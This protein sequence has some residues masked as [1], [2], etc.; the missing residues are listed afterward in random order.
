[1]TH[2]PEQLS[3]HGRT[4]EA[5]RAGHG[6]PLIVLE[7]GLGDDWSSWSSVLAPLAQRS[8]LLAYSRPG[9]GTSAAASTPRDIRTEAREL[10]ELLR[11]LG[12]RSP[13]LLVGH[14]LGGLI[15]QA[16]A[17]R[18]PNDVA[19]L[20]LVDAPH[21]DQI[22]VLNND[23]GE[24]GRA[25]RQ[26]ASTLTGAARLEYEAI[27]APQGG[28]FS[29]ATERYSGPVIVLI[30][31]LRSNASESYQEYRRAR[32]VE[33]AAQYPNAEVRRVF[34]EHYIQRERPLAVIDAV[35]EVLAR[36]R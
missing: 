21:P 28:H 5:V 20:V 17:A 9:Y 8:R 24:S 16:F 32:A 7:A 11:S 13:Y 10:H 27:V 1:M 26:F 3:A 25:Y 35:D 19:G 23:P 31:W 14:S 30:A 36:S 18:H 15:V 4:F 29:D 12:E 33:T 2:L 6:D 34:S 22:E